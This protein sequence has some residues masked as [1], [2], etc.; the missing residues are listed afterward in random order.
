MKTFLSTNHVTRAALGLT[1]A[2]LASPI[3]SC[4]Q[5]NPVSGPTVFLREVYLDPLLLS[6]GLDSA[7]LRAA[8][9]EMLSAAGRQASSR[10][11]STPA[12]DIALTVPRAVAGGDFGP[13][14]LLRVEVGRNLMENGFAR[15]L[16]WERTMELGEIMRGPSKREYLTWRSLADG[17]SSEIAAVVGA[18][19]S[20]PRAGA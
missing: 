1:L 11:Q 16:V 6:F 17:A 10:T 2:L 19:L 5:A 14:A 12:L 20:G 9:I 7:R 3:S 13:R 8:V 18:F 15:N 4:A